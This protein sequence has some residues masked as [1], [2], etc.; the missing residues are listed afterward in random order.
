MET[1]S[2]NNFPGE[3]QK[4]WNGERMLVAAMPAMIEKAN[5]E[6]LKNI[7][8][9]H[10]AETLQHKTALEGIFKQLNIVAEEKINDDLQNI[11][12]EGQMA[13][14]N[15]S[16]DRADDLVIDSARKIEQYEIAAYAL[17]GE[18]AKELGYEG[19]AQRLFLTQAEE[20]QANTKLIFLKNRVIHEE[21]V[22]QKIY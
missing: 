10:L 14:M 17:A 18:Y 6:G 9:L 8:S 22:I 16:E 3:L 20:I 7:L 15:A 12:Q 1:N 13:M 4:L 19:I 21:L 5:N 2:Q 11:L